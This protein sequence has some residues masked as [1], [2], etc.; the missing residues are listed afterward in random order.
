[1][2]FYFFGVNESST[3]NASLYELFNMHILF[4]VYKIKW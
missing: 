4:W 3:K 1:M 2:P